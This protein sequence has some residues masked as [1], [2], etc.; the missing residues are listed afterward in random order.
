MAEKKKKDYKAIENDPEAFD[1]FKR[2]FI[3]QAAR[4]ATYR[5]P[6]RNIA[7]QEARIERGFY[8]CSSCGGAFGPKEIEKDHKQPVED[9]KTGFVDY[10]KYFD[11]LLVPTSG[12]AVLCTSC[13]DAK[14]LVEN[15]QRRSYGQKPVVHKKKKKK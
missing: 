6:Y 8:K 1:K 12:W 10:N 2:N 3:K 13:H 4:K 5:W 11:R 15:E 14:T 9:V 7:L